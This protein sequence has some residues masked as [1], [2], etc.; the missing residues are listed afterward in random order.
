MLTVYARLRK[1][2]AMSSVL[3]SYLRVASLNVCNSSVL[4]LH[5]VYLRSK[6][7]TADNINRNAPAVCLD[8]LT[9]FCIFSLSISEL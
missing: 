9:Q 3:R 5:V 6:L 4:W 7:Q 8:F 1:Y 2:G